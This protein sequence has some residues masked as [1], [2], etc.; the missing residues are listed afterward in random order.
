MTDAAFAAF[1]VTNCSTERAALTGDYASNL[2]GLKCTP[3]AP[4]SAETR[5]RLVLDTPTALW[6]AHLQGNP[7]IKAGDRLVI[8]STKY[9]VKVKE[10]YTWLPTGDIRMRLIVEELKR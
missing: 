8:G 10:P 2:T 9:P 3:L 4:V 5:T 6:E 7:D 1:T